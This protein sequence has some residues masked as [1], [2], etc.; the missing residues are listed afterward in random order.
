MC[1]TRCATKVCLCKRDKRT[2]STLCHSN[3]T[4]CNKYV[5]KQKAETIDLTKVKTKPT[6]IKVWK[7]VGSTYLYEYDK[8][9]LQSADWLDDK[10]IHASEQLL[11]SNT[12]ISL[13][14]FKTQ[15]YK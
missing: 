13:L 3:K 9:V 4:C 1:T 14:D 8:M 11:S 6:E 12:R 10:L 2:C 7:I 15:F 5:E